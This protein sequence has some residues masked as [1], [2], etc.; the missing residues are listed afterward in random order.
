MI[1][2]FQ[3]QNAALATTLATCGV[4]FYKDSA[5]TPCPFLNIYDA[6]TLRRLGYK[7]IPLEEAARQ[8][9]RS[10]KKGIL[11]YSFER[12]ELCDRL[13]RSYDKQSASIAADDANSPIPTETPLDIEPEIAARLCCQYV[14]NRNW[15]TTF[16]R[17]STPFLSLEG[18]KHT[19]TENGK[20][21]TVGSFK[22]ISLNATKETRRLIGL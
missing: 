10:G 1:P 11:V 15:F 9:W 8:A 4:P 22:L 16:W 17:G 5:G 21:I 7:G 2:L 19:T 3:T 14:K 6:E 13:I 20:S 12:T 18:D